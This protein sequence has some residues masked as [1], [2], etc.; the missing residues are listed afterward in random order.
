[1]N[2]SNCFL[3]SNQFSLQ[4]LSDRI[5]FLEGRLKVLEDAIA[6]VGKCYSPVVSLLDYSVYY[7]PSTVGLIDYY[8]VNIFDSFN[9]D[10]TWNF[11]LGGQ[12]SVPVFQLVFKFNPNCHVPNG[13]GDAVL[14]ELNF[15]NPSYPSGVEWL[16]GMIIVNNVMIPISREPSILNFTWDAENA[17]FTYFVNLSTLLPTINW[18]PGSDRNTIFLYT[19]IRDQAV[20][21]PSTI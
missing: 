12:I 8:L 11:V 14:S 17:T 4:H 19:Y 18:V 15:D 20:V 21:H 1:M 7:N 10:R 9:G 3:Q 5:S 13:K 16:M 2:S 6:S